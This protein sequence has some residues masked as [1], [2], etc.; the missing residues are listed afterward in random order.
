MFCPCSFH[1]NSMN[2]LP[3][4]KDLPVQISQT[5]MMLEKRG[6]QYYCHKIWI[7]LIFKI[8]CDNPRITFFKRFNFKKPCH[9]LVFDWNHRKNQQNIRNLDEETF[10]GNFFLQQFFQYVG[11]PQYFLHHFFSHAL[12]DC[13]TSAIFSSIDSWIIF[14]PLFKI[15]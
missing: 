7:F 14:S 9:L 8:S 12:L 5:F 3:F 1:G 15:E 10:L 2:N 11:Y 6:K 13:L 4:E